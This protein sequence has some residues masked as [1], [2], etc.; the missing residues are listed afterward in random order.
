[1]ARIA[2]HRRADE[3]DA[4][5]GAGLGEFLVLGQEAVAGMDG[6][7]AGGQRRLDDLVDH[8]VG[9]AR[10]RR[11]DAD[12]LVGQAH[13]ARAGVGL[14]IHGDGADAHAPRGLDDAAGDLPPVGDQY[15]RE[16]G[17]RPASQSSWVCASPERPVMPSRPSVSLLWRA[18]A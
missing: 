16:H 15:F 8:Q 12:G 14:G 2:A 5:R 18:G 17:F 10:R 9:L 11:A 3:D 13:V 6:L 7:G 4:G 1:M